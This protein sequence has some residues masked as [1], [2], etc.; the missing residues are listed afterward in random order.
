MF[1][2]FTPRPTEAILIL[3]A[4]LVAF[5]GH[6]LAA[7][8]E[9]LLAEASVLAALP[10]AL[11]PPAVLA[12]S[13]LSLHLLLCW[14]RLQG[15]QL[16]LPIVGLLTAIGLSV[17]FRLQGSGGVWQQ[18]TRGW[19]PGLIL[20]TLFILY[21]GL[22][23][24][25]RRQW[26]I[27]ISLAGLFLLLV[28]AFFGVVDETGARLALK[29]GPLPAVQT[30]E[31]IKLALIIFL[32][33]YIE[34]EGEKIEGRPARMIGWFRFPSPT[35]FIPG[36]VFV[37]LATLALVKMSDFGAI[38]ILGVLFV[39]MLYAGFQP[40]VFLSV[41]AIALIMSL[42]MGLVLAFAWD[43]PSV[44]EQRVLAFRDPWSDEPL[45]ING[46]P[47]DI[48]IAEGPGYQIQQAVYAIIAGGLT[49]TGLGYG[50]PYY[51]PLAHSDFIF[52]AIAEELGIMGSLAILAFFII[53]LLRI[54]RVGILL[55]AGQVFERLL[56]VGIA[57]HL[58]TQVFVMV[59]GTV[60]LLPLT[61]VTVPFLS[62]G[63]VAMMVNLMEVGMVFA[64]AQR[65][66]S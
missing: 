16:I 9:Q 22:I 62:Q 26:P 30:S 63:G 65:L 35:Y 21:P 1:R 20:M 41:A 55:P 56:L 10:G 17:I 45:I 42:F 15:E 36:V 13:L 66:Q 40:S 54:L 28:T 47:S 52:A 37:A 61:G 2:R 60:N 8:A 19:I 27:L 43:V 64:L 51:V 48:T 6:I 49:G 59:G 46:V 50:S 33:W 14:R 5:L 4:V 11:V 58:F 25:I 32:A 3:I 24:R 38:L 12:V 44:I 7:S 29:L 31:L 23:E 53:L 34:S 57:L 39:G 18:I